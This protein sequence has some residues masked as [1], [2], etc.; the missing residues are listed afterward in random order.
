MSIPIRI[1][2]REI[3]AIQLYDQSEAA[4]R[5]GGVPWRHW[6]MCAPH[7]RRNWRDRAQQILDEALEQAQEDHDEDA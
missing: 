7:D 6:W 1:G 3:L 2:I 4:L 5:S